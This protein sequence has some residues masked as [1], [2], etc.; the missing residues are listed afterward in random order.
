MRSGDN[1]A[2]LIGKTI[3]VRVIE[4]DRQSNRLILSQKMPDAKDIGQIA[5]LLAKINIGDRLSGIVT[6]VLPFGI[7]VEVEIKESKSQRVKE[8]KKDDD[9]LGKLEGL[10]HISEISWEKV[11]DPAK[12][13]KVG[14]K[15]DVMVVA[16]DDTVGRLN[17]S[18]KQ[19]A[20]DPFLE[21]SKQYSKDQVVGGNVDRITP[22]GVFVALS[23]GV[24]GLIH[25]SKIP[26][27]IEYEIGQALECTVEAVDTKARRITL[28]P[29]VREKPILYR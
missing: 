20:D 7:F 24:E 9:G 1:I 19:L 10:V 25:I 5:G 21:L 27:N 17:L 28:A 23:G 8:S 14:D 2:D 29:V 4:V 16:K 22:Y 6:A 12:Y 11:E 3:T 18:I 13:F 26:P 15:V